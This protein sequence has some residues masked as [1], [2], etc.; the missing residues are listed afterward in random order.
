MHFVAGGHGLVDPAI[1]DDGLVEAVGQPARVEVEL[2]RKD[3]V[4]ELERR[5]NPGERLE[6][7]LLKFDHHLDC[8]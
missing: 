8:E 3:A 1:V 5:R 2:A 4:D 7:R 6:V